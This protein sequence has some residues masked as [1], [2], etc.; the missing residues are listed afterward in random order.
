MVSAGQWGLPVSLTLVG[1]LPPGVLRVPGEGWG[2]LQ[3]SGPCV[4]CPC[5]L[6][7]TARP[8]SPGWESTGADGPL[9]GA[10]AARPIHGGGSL[11][12]ME[13]R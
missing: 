2:Q 4:L 10:G 7:V 3:A 8:R 1:R 9:K 13:L 11:P 5:P 12:L 6:G